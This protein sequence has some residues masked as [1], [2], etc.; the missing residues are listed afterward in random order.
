M[1]SVSPAPVSQAH[2]FG[3]LLQKPHKWT[4]QHQ[5]FL[6]VREESEVSPENILDPAFLPCDGDQGI[7]IDPSQL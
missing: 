5:D 4:A 1:S 6:R 7:D 2:D 3:F